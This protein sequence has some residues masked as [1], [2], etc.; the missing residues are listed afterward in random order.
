MLMVSYQPRSP[1]MRQRINLKFPTFKTPEHP[2]LYC[3]FTN[4]A[5][6]NNT[7]KR[8]VFSKGAWHHRRLFRKNIPSL[9]KLHTLGVV[10]QITPRSDIRSASAL[11][12]TA[13]GAWFYAPA[14]TATRL[15]S[16]IRTAPT[17]PE[18]MLTLGAATHWF[19]NIKTLTPHTKIAHVPTR[20]DTPGILARAAGCSC[21]IIEN[22]LWH[23]WAL[24]RLPSGVNK[25]ISNKNWVMTGLAE[26]STKA[27][28]VHKKS[29]KYHQYGTR[30][31]VRGV[32]KNPNDHPHGGRTKSVKYARTPWGRTAKK[33]RAPSNKT[34][35]KTLSKRKK[36]SKLY[37][38]N[39]IDTVVDFEL[40]N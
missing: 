11:I 36:K 5:G 22:T 30:P 37:I 25:L 40:P 4:N 10:T 18:L 12:R 7:G 24:I 8:S 9:N 39:K 13:A 34:E 6:R 15:F 26:P 31:Q 14:T 1:S 23:D 16:Y 20:A 3:G 2:N 19:W 17:T 28:L 27:M 35:W 32:A 38:D 29:S 21:L 33:S